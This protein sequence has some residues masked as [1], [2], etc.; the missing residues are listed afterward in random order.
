MQGKC[1]EVKAF[2]TVSTLK[3]ELYAGFLGS[4]C[5]PG[6]RG[7]M[8]SETSVNFYWNNLVSGPRR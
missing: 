4:F 6:D 7:S 2:E 8:F 5:C 3:G 1:C